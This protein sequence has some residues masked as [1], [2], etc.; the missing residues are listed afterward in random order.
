LQLGSGP[1]GSALVPPA[2]EDGKASNHGAWRLWSVRKTA[3]FRKRLTSHPR[4]KR[5]RTA[6]SSRGQ[7]RADGVRPELQGSDPVAPPVAA[8]LLP[9]PR[10]ELQGSDPVAP[11]GCCAV[12]APPTN[13]TLGARSTLGVRSARCGS[14][15]HARGQTRTLRVRP[16]CCAAG[17]RCRRRVG[18]LGVGRRLGVWHLVDR[19]GLRGRFDP[20]VVEFAQVNIH[21]RGLPRGASFQ[22]ARGPRMG[23][24]MIRVR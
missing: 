22:T 23:D 1:V 7:S 15:P 16:R 21:A 18:R 12:A 13:A 4:R 2:Q 17:T 10:P 20:A 8:P 5:V 6:M 19:H 9:L 24:S 3:P 14:G 11:P